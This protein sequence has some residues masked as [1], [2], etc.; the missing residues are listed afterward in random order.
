MSSKD[1]HAMIYGV[2]TYLTLVSS[3]LVILAAFYQLSH[4]SGLASPARSSSF[5]LPRK[6]ALLSQSKTIQVSLPESSITPHLLNRCHKSHVFFCTI[7]WEAK[8]VVCQVWI[9]V[10]YNDSSQNA[11][12]YLTKGKFTIIGEN[13]RKPIIFRIFSSKLFYPHH[14]FHQ[15][16]PSLQLPSELHRH[17]HKQG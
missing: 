11:L 6:V 1:I 16:C 17:Q 5:L 8:H 15:V 3:D 13:H 12:C 4:I 10:F 7:W 9:Y 2:L 14:S